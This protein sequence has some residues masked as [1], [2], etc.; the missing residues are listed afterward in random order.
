MERTFLSIASKKLDQAQN[1]MEL[2]K[3][4]L[5]HYLAYMTSALVIAAVGPKETPHFSNND[6]LI[7]MLRTE[8]DEESDPEFKAV[9]RRNADLIKQ[10]LDKIAGEFRAYA[11]A[12][13]LEVTPD[14]F[15]MLM[16]EHSPSVA[17]IGTL[18][19]GLVERLNRYGK[20]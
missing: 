16:R 18:Q 1:A 9:A 5:A 4:G 19:A 11:S 13:N 3:Y 8:A 7:A 20:R 14:N 12:R 2:K 15:M 6:E 17:E 10:S